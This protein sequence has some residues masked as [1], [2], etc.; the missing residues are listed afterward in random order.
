MSAPSTLAAGNGNE[1]S[2]DIAQ[3][4][5]NGDVVLVVGSGREKIQVSSHFLMFISPVFR[6]MF[7]APMREGEALRNKA[8]DS[9][10][11]IILSDDNPRAMRL[12]LR[13]L[14]GSDAGTNG[15]PSEEVKNIAILADKY[16]MVERFKFA[17][18]CWIRF[19]LDKDRSPGMC[20]NLL[21]AAYMLK[22]DNHFFSV[23]Q[24]MIYNRG[25]LLKFAAELP[26]QDLG[27]RLGMA[28]EE[29]RAA[30]NDQNQ[31]VGLCLDCFLHATESFTK[32]RDGCKFPER[33]LKNLP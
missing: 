1:N 22:L 3:V 29:L 24:A 26:Q 20:W 6:A 14:Y 5:R 31:H 10:F 4:G 15:L 12:A 27:M 30:R 23:S 25:S 19:L 13:V 21:V 32:K 17:G 33:H 16:A 28:I 2:S 18:L 9:P 11:E 8:D 7:E